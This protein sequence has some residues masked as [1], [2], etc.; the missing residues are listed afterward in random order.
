MNSKRKGSAGERE[1]AGILCA[2]G[3]DA[4]RNDQR[5]VSGLENPD[6]ALSGVHIEVKRCEALRLYDAVEQA[7]R[8]AN[9]KAVPVVMHRK[10]HAP[11]LVI[12]PLD[13][14]IEL[15]REWASGRY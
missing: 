12:M 6:V 11:W 1:L 15:Y 7:A 8:D 9:G 2:Y 10:N 5:F 14:W 4:H 13:S 3:Y